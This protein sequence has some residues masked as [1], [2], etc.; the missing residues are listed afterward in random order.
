MDRR[1]RT[2][3]LS[4]RARA[5]SYDSQLANTAHVLD[6]RAGAR[7]R[8]GCPRRVLARHALF[9]LARA[10]QGRPGAQLVYSDEDKLDELGRRCEPYFKPDFARDLLYAQNYVAHL[11]VYRRKLVETAGGLRPGFEGS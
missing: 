5:G 3:R 2:A 8:R 4:R 10:L 7:Q 1:G 9:S 11:A 6:R